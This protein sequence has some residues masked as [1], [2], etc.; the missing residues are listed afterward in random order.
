MDWDT[1][2]QCVPHLSFLLSSTP[3]LL[4]LNSDSNNLVLTCLSFF[5]H[6][7]RL[8]PTCAELARNIP[9]T[10]SKYAFDMFPTLSQPSPSLSKTYCQ[11][12]P[13]MLFPCQ[14]YSHTKI[15]MSMEWEGVFHVHKFKM[16]VIAKLQQGLSFE[17]CPKLNSHSLPLQSDYCRKMLFYCC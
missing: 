8:L 13:P 10:Y 1:L 16:A 4:Y 15:G 2:I 11:N 3:Y 6:A 9:P 14:Q 5:Q 12:S 17:Y 7:P